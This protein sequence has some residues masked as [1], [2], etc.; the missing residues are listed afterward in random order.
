VTS[1]ERRE[2]VVVGGGHA[3]QAAALEARR[4]GVETC[5]VDQRAELDVRAGGATI[6]ADTAVW[7]IWGRERAV[8]AP[9]G[10]T[11]MLVADHVVPGIA[12]LVHAAGFSGHGVMHAP[13]SALLL[14][15]LVAGDAI[16]GRVRLPPPFESHWL[17]LDAF[18][19]ARDFA[20]STAETTVL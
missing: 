4:A 7:G 16:D 10:P 20:D 6:C 12:N 14:E 9:T 5:I 18:R 8:C 19:P 3:G 13:I 1:R 17:D 15:A 2:L 11:R